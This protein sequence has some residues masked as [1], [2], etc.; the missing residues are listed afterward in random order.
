MSQYTQRRKTHMR[1]T[2]TGCRRRWGRP[3]HILRPIGAD[4][5]IARTSRA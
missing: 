2:R 5:G 4:R 1:C 3:G